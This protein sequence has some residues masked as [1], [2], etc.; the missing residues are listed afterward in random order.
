[1]AGIVNASFAPELNITAV[2]E[3][4]DAALRHIDRFTEQ[5]WE[6]LAKEGADNWQG[7]MDWLIGLPPEEFCCPPLLALLP[8]ELIRLRPD[9]PQNKLPP[10]NTAAQLAARALLIETYWRPACCE[11][12]PSIAMEGNVILQAYL[13]ATSTLRY[14]LLEA[15]I[16]TVP[17]QSLRALLSRWLHSRDC[18]DIAAQLTSNPL[19]PTMITRTEPL[20][21]DLLT[22][23][24]ERL[25]Q[26]ATQELPSIRFPEPDSVQFDRLAFCDNKVIFG[27]TV[28]GVG[29]AQQGGNIYLKVKRLDESHDTFMAEQAMLCWLHTEAAQLQLASGTVKP[30]GTVTG[31]PLE[32]VLCQL[33][34]ST[35]QIC[36]LV[37]AVVYNK[38]DLIKKTR[39]EQCLAKYTEPTEGRPWSEERHEHCRSD[40]PYYH[41]PFM[42]TVEQLFG[43]LVHLPFDA[44]KKADFIDDLLPNLD[45]SL[46]NAL[47]AERPVPLN[48]GIRWKL[49]RA[50]LADGTLQTPVTL[51]LFSTPAGANYH[52][53]VTDSDQSCCASQPLAERPQLLALRAWLQDYGRL[54]Q[55]GIVGPPACDMFHTWSHDDPTPYHFLYRNRAGIRECPRPGRVQNFNGEPTNYPN[56][57]MQPLTLRDG[58]D[59]FFIAPCGQKESQERWT[60]R[61]AL[62]KEDVYRPP[63]VSNKEFVVDSLANAWL[64]SLLLLGRI[65]S[66]PEN[67]APSGWLANGKSEQTTELA[68]LL[69]EMA[70][71]LFSHSFAVDRTA[72]HTV[73]CERD[74]RRLL[75]RCAREMQAWMTDSFIA[76]L[77]AKEV[78]EWLYPDYSGERQDLFVDPAISSWLDRLVQR[79]AQS[80]H[81][82]E[83]DLGLPYASTPLQGIEILT[84]K[85]LAE[86]VLLAAQGPSDTIG[87]HNI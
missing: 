8:V 25:L 81:S 30:G 72:L 41:P 28:G 16:Q 83:R 12:Y 39:V 87:E 24:A 75:E 47:V 21:Q 58:G 38:K 74:G 61:L 34:L 15:V 68:T 43:F 62:Q 4:R 22:A 9:L 51:S 56:I 57:G 49:L 5:V 71:D 53:Y 78:P 77:F 18:K 66:T 80:N 50:T 26:P 33:N 27:R 36:S 2:K 3:A 23:G 73:L 35:V 69:G 86:S 59:A 64:G 76:P 70:V 32:D 45:W 44:E 46:R 10:N 63:A 84:K 65:L 85:A 60:A 82:T 19:H 67:G 55:K 29:A 11:E 79:I 1:M 20:L 42:R 31:A 13:A 7:C 48:D 17:P 37:H 54:F 52:Q 6:Q 40:D 14:Q